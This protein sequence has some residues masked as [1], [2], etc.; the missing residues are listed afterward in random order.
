MAEESLEEVIERVLGGEHEAF[1]GIVRHYQRE[2]WR[3]VAGTWKLWA[4][5]SQG[6][7]GAED[8]VQ[9]VFVDAFLHLDQYQPG[10]D[11]TAWI[12]TIARNR[13]RQQLRAWT[14]ENRRLAL[15]RQHLLD[16][17][18]DDTVAARREEAYREALTDCC[19]KLAPQAA[20]ALDLRYRHALTLE[21]IAVRLGS[22][23]EAVRKVLH[24]TQLL[25]KDCIETRLAQT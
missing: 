2:V 8:L 3:V 7:S 15:Y 13:V 11:F 20:A 16:H 24:R 12:K 18:S 9:Q 14:R 22:T 5:V 1:A 23:A 19:R 6:M 25:L 4:G 21:E 17:L 10:T